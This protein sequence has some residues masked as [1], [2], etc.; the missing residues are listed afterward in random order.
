MENPQ[1]FVAVNYIDCDDGYKER[2]EVLFKTRAGA[3]DRLPGFQKMHVLKPQE[4]AGSY[5]IVSY[6]DSE[7]NFK[8]WTRSPEFLEG[9]KRGFED[10][11]RAKAEGKTPPMR[12]SFKTYTI[13]TN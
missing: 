3:I 10:I 6:W 2:F 8:Q 11:A 5:L 13:L 9:H 7:E 12:S 1:G 4:E